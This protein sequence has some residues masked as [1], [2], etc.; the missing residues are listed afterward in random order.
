MKALLCATV[1]A[2]TTADL[3]RARDLVQEADLVELRLDHVLD[4]DPAGAL[5]DRKVPAIVTCRPAWEGG[6]FRGSEEEREA[7]LTAALQAGADYVDVEA[8]A[9]FDSL[10]RSTAGRRIVLSRHHFDGAPRDLRAE[11]RWLRSSATQIVKL[12]V[13]TTTLDDTCRLAEAV[14]AEE[15]RPESVV[16]VGMGPAGVLT[17]VLP[18]RFGSAWTYCGDGVAPGQL[19]LQVLLHQFD[20]RRLSR[21][22][23][24]YGVVG[25]RV[26]HSLSPVMHNAALR[27]SN[28][29]AVYVPLAASDVDDFLGFARTFSLRGASVTAPF[30][31]EMAQRLADIDEASRRVGAINTIRF[32]A[33]RCT[34][35]NTDVPGFLAPLRG[36]VELDGMRVAILGAGGA[37]RAVAVALQSVGASVAVYARRAEQARAVAAL[38][39]GEAG[40]MPPPFD[41]WDLIV[42]ATPLGML[43]DADQTPLDPTRFDGRLAYDLVY[44]PTRTRFLRDAVARGCQAIGGLHMLVEQAA[45]QF[46]WW[47]GR[48]ADRRVFRAAA[49]SSLRETQGQSES[50]A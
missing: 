7:I 21:D 43:P 11:L 27:A 2:K 6:A 23:A 3:R 34:G 5:A 8:R 18:D 9:G 20:V 46:E 49:E 29:D 13:A 48:V 45:L 36:R 26:S 17:R 40:T 41:S 31:V 4:P 39:N 24:V 33:D 25:S 50:L 37:A 42:N 14:A 1:V 19:P 16:I 38:V 35:I 44:N 12:A 32:D 30:K 15:E 47:T 22:T 10:I 28:L